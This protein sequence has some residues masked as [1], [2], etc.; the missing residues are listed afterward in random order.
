MNMDSA[1]FQFVLYGLA[2]ALLSNLSRSR[3]WRSGLR[4]VDREKRVVDQYLRSGFPGI[5]VDINGL[6]RWEL[7]VEGAMPEI[8]P[9]ELALLNAGTSLVRSLQ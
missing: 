3:V 2:A 8:A 1:S 5:A 4:A 7:A 9:K 6:P